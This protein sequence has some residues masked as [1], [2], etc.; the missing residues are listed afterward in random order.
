MT[1]KVTNQATGFSETFE[2]FMDVAEAV[3]FR[4]EDLL[5][6]YGVNGVLTLTFEDVTPEPVL[7][8]ELPEDEGDY[9]TL[10]NSP[11]VIEAIQENTGLLRQLIDAVNRIT[12]R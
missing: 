1:I 5:R 7:E 6:I 10:F 3:E 9:G 12:G 11:D 8:E 2:D 4:G